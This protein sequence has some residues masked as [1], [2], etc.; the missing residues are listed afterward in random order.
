MTRTAKINALK[1]VHNAIEDDQIEEFNSD[2]A[3]INSAAQPTHTLVPIVTQ[4]APEGMTLDIGKQFKRKIEFCDRALIR[5]HNKDANKRGL[6]LG[7]IIFQKVFQM[8]T[9]SCLSHFNT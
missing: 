9:A 4:N 8:S 3:L 5:I 1:A 2:N 6:S 7:W